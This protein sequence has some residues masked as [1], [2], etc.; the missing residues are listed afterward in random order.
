MLDLLQI[1]GH[2]VCRNMSLKG[3]INSVS[4]LIL[5]WHNKLLAGVRDFECISTSLGRSPNSILICFWVINRGVGR[6]GFQYLSGFDILACLR[7][8]KNLNHSEILFC[9]IKY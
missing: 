2:A 1:T 8:K 4:F 5:F 3:Q 7:N 6:E 9:H